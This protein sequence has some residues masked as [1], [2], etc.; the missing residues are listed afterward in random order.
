M[1]SKTQ[2]IVLAI[3]L[4]TASFAWYAVFTS[5]RGVLEVSVLDV[6]QGDAIF[7]ETPS[8]AQVL[9]DGGPGRSVLSQL[10]AIMPAYDRSIDVVIATHT[11]YDH[12][13][14]LVEVLK[15]YDVGMVVENGFVA[16]TGM[17][18]DWEKLIADKKIKKYAVLAGDR[19]VFDHGIA[20]DFYGPFVE[21]FLPMPKKANEVMIVSRLVYGNDSFLFAGDLERG[22]EV[23]LANSNLDIK[24]TVLKVAHHGSKYANTD[25]FFQKANPEYAV[26]SVGARNRYGHPTPEALGRI[27]N[28]H[29]KLFRT[30]RDGRVTFESDGTNLRVE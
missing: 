27:A 18:A 15:N 23:R 9:I 5:S 24:S 14:G 6:G 29:A 2:K 26:I 19:M 3:L 1:F 7:F 30:D 21:D 8:G 13:A 20:L 17:Y 25:L 4:L 16:S 12:L 10:G 28:T 22:D 11:D